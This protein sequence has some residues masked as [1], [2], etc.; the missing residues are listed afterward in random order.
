MIERIRELSRDGLLVLVGIQPDGGV[1]QLYPTSRLRVEEAFPR[2]KMFRSLVL[3]HRRDSDFEDWHGPV[4]ERV[5]ELLTGLTL[6][7]IAQ[8]G[9]VRIYDPE[10]D[11][12]LWE[13][14]PTP[15]S[16]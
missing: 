5:V 16:R 10:G 6:D 13:W 7:Q 1:Y 11:R 9:G 15:V 2:A 12:V 14:K 4:W 8:L 3:H